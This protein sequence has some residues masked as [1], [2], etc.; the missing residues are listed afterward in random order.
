MREEPLQDY[1]SIENQNG[2]QR[3]TRHEPLTG[4][5]QR[6]REARRICSAGQSPNLRAKRSI[7]RTARRCRLRS[8]FSFASCA[9]FSQSALTPSRSTA[10]RDTFRRRANLSA[11]PKVSLSTLTLTLILVAIALHKAVYHN[12]RVGKPFRH[13]QLSNSNRPF[14]AIGEISDL[15]VEMHGLD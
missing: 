15:F 10:L 4:F 3:R 7:S 9:S 6:S 5:V 12:L 14:G 2:T 11:R 1:R 13:P 8:A